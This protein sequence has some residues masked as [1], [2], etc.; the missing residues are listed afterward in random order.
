[1]TYREPGTVAALQFSKRPA[2]DFPDVVEE[3]DI[4]LN[5]LAAKRRSVSWDCED[6]AIID[7]D[8]VRIALGWLPPAQDTE[9]WYLVI[10][11]G[12]GRPGTGGPVSPDIC[13]HLKT[14]I[15]DRA[16]GYLDCDSVLHSRADQP[17]GADLIDL[18][19][20][21]L[22]ET[23]R[24]ATR[25]AAAQQ[26]SDDNVMCATGHTRLHEAPRR[27]S[28]WYHP[29]ARTAERKTGREADAAEQDLRAAMSGQS[30]GQ[31]PEE[32]S[33]P[34]KLTVYTLGATMLIHVPA[35]GAALLV[36]TA[37]REHYDAPMAA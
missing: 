8:A 13:E 27:T 9:S 11:V 17:V 6:I 37:L 16:H 30:D 3:L 19:S 28:P 33:L 25:P 10:A 18:V 23:E 34:M 5:S 31:A 24:A 26:A 36:Y 7:R 15:V 22:R 1:M 32:A 12:A 4:A 2:I 20:D 14:M 21:R 29:A 35:I